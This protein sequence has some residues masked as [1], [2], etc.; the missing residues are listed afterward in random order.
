LIPFRPA[1]DK[2]DF[3]NVVGGPYP[4]QAIAAGKIDELMEYLRQN[5]K[6]LNADDCLLKPKGN[7]YWFIQLIAS[8]VEMD[9]PIRSIP[10]PEATC[11]IDKNSRRGRGATAASCSKSPGSAYL[12][13]L[14]SDIRKCIEPAGEADGIAFEISTHSGQASRECVVVCGKSLLRGRWWGEACEPAVTMLAI[15]A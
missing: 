5:G 13:G 7:A 10:A 8:R 11:L 12:R 14:A 3:E 1:A 2:V 6:N 9:S 15:R 4:Y